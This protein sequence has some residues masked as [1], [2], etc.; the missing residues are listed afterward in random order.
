MAWLHVGRANLQP[1]VVEHLPVHWSSLCRGF[2]PSLLIF[3]HHQRDLQGSAQFKF[4][5]YPS[6]YDGLA[7]LLIT[8]IPIRISHNL[9]AMIVEQ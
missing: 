7:F 3:L 1:V 9:D 6:A 4:V 8:T 2:S 5:D